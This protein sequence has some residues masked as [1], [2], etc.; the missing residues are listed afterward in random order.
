VLLEIADD[1]KA[2][3]LDLDED[4]NEDDSEN[5]HASHF[6]RL[7][8][9]KIRPGMFLLLRT[10]GSG[11]YIV[12]I[13]DRILG[14]EAQRLR[15]MQEE[16]KSALRTLV[17]SKGLLAASI[18]LLDLGSARANEINVRNWMSPR[19]IRP[20]DYN[21]FLA[22]LRLTGMENLAHEHWQ[23]A[24][25]IDTAHRKAGFQ[26]RKLLLSQVRGADLRTLQRK[27]RL[28]FHMPEVEGGTLTAFRVEH[29]M[30]D[31]ILVPIS[32]LGRPFLIKER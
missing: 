23:A 31:S 7:A 20:R 25:A 27:G 5:E 14:R 12:P 11:D 17:Q 29:V 6:A 2:L 1:V 8:T 22:I 32:R 16:W 4:D 3:I 9:G 30:P 28:D 19:N 18:E 13:A 24:E 26:L 10:S 15:S 21:D